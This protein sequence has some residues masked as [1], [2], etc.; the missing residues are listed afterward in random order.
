MPGHS[1]TDTDR[2]A[3]MHIHIIG[4]GVAQ[5]A[6]LDA[7]ALAALQNAS[8]VI[9]SPRQLATVA[10]LL[11]EPQRLPLPS[12]AQLQPLIERLEV[13]NNSS[14]A[15]LASG[16]PL[17]Y[18]IGRWF[19][20]RFAPERLSYYPAVSSIQA[21]C[22]ALGLSLQDVEV[23]S[24]H[25]RAPQKIRRRLKKNRTLVLLTDKNS[26]PQRL[27][28]ECIA[29][30]FDLSTLFVC[31]ALGYE[32]QRVRSFAAAELA[33]AAVEFDPL[34]ITVIQTRGAGGILPEFPGIP[35][36]HFMTGREAGKGLLTKREV[37]L[38]AVSLLQPASGDVIW[39]IG[40][41]C[42]GVAVELA[43]WNEHIRV[44]AIEHNPQRLKHLEANRQKF[45]VVDNLDIVAGRAPDVFVGL[46]QVDK[47]FIGGSDGALP[48]LIDDVWRRLAQTGVVVATAVTET[49]RQQLIEFAAQRRRE[50]DGET[51]TLQIAVN[52]AD[53]LAGQLLY[54]PGL[55]VTLFRF[56]KTDRVDRQ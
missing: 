12:L 27:A 56:R 36:G 53:S 45:G 49:S 44:L 37:R 19:G 40:A 47:A 46:A 32:R 15:V 5:T 42:G 35:D 29:A 3:T 2:S 41:G 22:H 33:A 1:A 11:G 34:H 9:G 17:Y 4:L 7:P 21:V 16:D 20:Q 18:G 52:R 54:R 31:E 28:Q 51:E 55:A 43:C 10:G 23:V 14:I 13:A 38:A 50:G 26:A 8:R 25:G 39:D 24:L 30:G 48:A 6:I